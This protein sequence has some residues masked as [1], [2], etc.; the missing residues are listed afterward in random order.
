MP[1]EII[2]LQVGQAGNQVGRAFWN[3]ALHEHAANS[4]TATFKSTKSDATRT[5]TVFEESMSTFFRNQHPKSRKELQAGSEILDLKAR[6]C[7]IDMEDGVLSETMRGPL[8]D[9]FNSNQV[10]SDV[11][12]AGNNWAHGYY[13]YGSKYQDEI[14]ELV[15]AQAEPC[16]SLQSFFL[17]HSLGGGT[18]S[19][20]GTRVL[21][22]LSDEYRGV[23][24]FTTSVLP[25]ALGK[26]GDSDVVVA[27]YN[28]VSALTANDASRAA[29]VQR[30]EPPKTRSPLTRN[31]TSR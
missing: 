28:S 31:S 12:G 22:L 15:R 6:A 24:R 27:P 23:Y 19:G 16:D 4:T 7:L 26:G 5:G 20:L 18:G 29:V 3:R 8:K 30:R 17:M 9:L 11:S 13:E 21:Q 14:L 10:L 25:S 2:T 1:R